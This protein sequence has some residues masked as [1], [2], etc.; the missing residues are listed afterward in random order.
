MSDN[1]RRF[2]INDENDRLAIPG[3]NCTG[4]DL[5]GRVADSDG[6]AYSGVAYEFNPAWLIPRDQ[7]QARIE[8]RKEKQE[9]II[10]KVRYA[11][12]P[13]K[14]QGRTNYCWVNA[15]VH[16]LEISRMQANE[17]PVSLSPAWAGSII[18]RGRNVG[19]WGRE[20]IEFLYNHGTVPSFVCSDN[21][22]SV[23]HNTAGNRKTASR[24]R[25]TDWV[26]CQP[27]NVE[28]MVSLLLRDY[29]GAAGYNWW[30]H[31]VAVTDV[32]WIDGDVATIIRNSWR[33][34]GDF[35]FGVLQ[36]SRMLADDLV[37][38][39]AGRPMGATL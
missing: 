36:G 10:D 2:I 34:W 13:H 22:Q 24:Y 3:S 30:G 28:Q 7:W 16:A 27:R 15:P 39:L 9:R 17:E 6:F 12:L 4:L 31:E 35:G 19:G 8:E 18:K 11:K 29:C 1:H 37:F 25:V 26:E 21:D 20:A 5:S 23:R 14:D 32:D 33:G 38:C